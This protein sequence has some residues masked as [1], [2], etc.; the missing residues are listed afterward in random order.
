MRRVI[1]LFIAILCLAAW[2]A[3]AQQILPMQ[4]SGWTQPTGAVP[5]HSAAE[6]P[7]ILAEYGWKSTDA[8]VYG[9]SSKGFGVVLYV[10]SDPSGAYGLY[11]FFR[12][13]DMARSNLTDHSSIS[14]DRALVLVGD[15]VLDI[16]GVDL[17]KLEPQLKALVAAVEP[18]AHGGA[19]PVLGEY[20]PQKNMIEKTDRYVLGARTLDQLFPGGIGNSVGFQSHAEAELA[21]YRLGGHDATLLLVDFPTDQLAQRQLAE[22]QK[23]FNVNGANQSDGSPVLFAKRSATLLAIVSGASSQTEANTLLDQIQL[24]TDRS[25]NEPTFQFKEPSIGMM[26]VGSII[27]AGTI[28]MFALIAGISFGG[29]RLVVKRV[30]PGKIFDTKRHLQVLQL[31]L[32]SKPINSDDFYGYSAP[33]ATA[34]P[35]DKN[36]PDRVALRIFR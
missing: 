21:H 4:V 12:T 16:H 7:A 3:H 33:T 2:P 25:W 32:G 27:G 8:A 31:G 6:T 5:L 30:M 19:L 35:V 10:M 18:K 22:L 20:L 17:P 24:E 11:S 14:S 13:P 36:L 34:N 9:D 23:N 29:L 28:C 15:L 26:I 1:G